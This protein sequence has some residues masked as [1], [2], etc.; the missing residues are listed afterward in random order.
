MKSNF[1]RILKFPLIAVL[2]VA[3]LAGLGF[4]VMG[5]WNWLMPALFGLKLIGYWQAMGLIVLSKILFGGFR[6]VGG[7]GGY[8]RHDMGERWKQRTPEEREK[9]RQDL[10]ACWR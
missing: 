10:R 2:C 8:R 5:L 3:M 9:F 7:R 6:G 4:V 1:L